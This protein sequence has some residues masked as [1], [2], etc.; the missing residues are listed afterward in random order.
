MRERRLHYAWF[1]LAGI[2]LIRGFAGGGLNM[3]SSLFLAPVSEELGVGIGSLSIYFSITSIVTILFLPYAGK[4]INR[5]DIRMITAVGAA[6]QAF[7][8]AGF[9]LLHKVWG[10]YFLAVP[11]AMGATILVS[12]LGPILINRWFAKNEALMMGIQMAFV[13]LFGALLQPFT[14]GLIEERGWRQAYYLL[15]GLTFAVVLIAAFLLLKN[16]PEDKNLTP[17]GSGIKGQEDAG[18]AEA[19]LAVTE[20]E[21]M[22]SIS[23]YLL[24]IF[25]TAF[26]GVGVFTQHIPTYGK[27]LGYSMKDIGTVL[28]YASIGNALGSIII[29]GISDRIGCLKTCYGVIFAGF[30]AVFGFLFS[31][32]G[33]WI[34]GLSTFLHGLTSSGIMVLA[35]ILTLQFFGQKDYEKIYAK[36][37]M[38]A[39][40][41]SIVLIPAYGFVHDA[42]DS[43]IPVL[44]GMAILLAVSLFSIAYGWKK[45]CTSEGC[46]RWHKK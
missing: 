15:G 42:L 1:I 38:G 34:F 41:A 33:F 32:N 6:L 18:R 11:Y 14:S 20:K 7:S 36:V 40:L 35:P 10:W 24:L 31:G 39:P 43:Y 44:W 26:T 28:A 12:L 30:L 19:V 45:R 8:F 17:Y 29:G 22:R 37:S 21:A 27:I 25:M 5:Y 3:T 2:I 16:R 23:F 13:G 4:L 46:P 9:G